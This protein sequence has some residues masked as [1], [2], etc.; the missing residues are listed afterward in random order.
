MSHP[1]LARR[2]CAVAVVAA[3]TVLA[4]SSASAAKVTSLQPWKASNTYLARVDLDGRAAPKLKPV[5]K[6]NHVRAGQWV[7]ITCQ[8]T[9]QMAY[10]SNIWDKVDGLY[11][12]DHYLKTY[13]DGFLA[14]VPRCTTDVPPPPP[15]PPPPA[16]PTRDELASAA[17]KVAFE[18]VYGSNWRIYKA[19]YPETPDTAHSLIWKTNGCSVPEAILNAQWHGVPIG[20]GFGYYAKLFVKSCD[21]H[22]FGY[23]NYG[24]K[25]NGL[26]LDPSATRRAQIDDRL[27]ANMDYQCKRIFSRKY[28]EAVQRGLCYKAS[29]AFY[30]AVHNFAGSHF[31]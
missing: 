25:T 3:A 10:G 30:W 2:A 14:G 22:D 4:P 19:K 16:G 31:S 1:V 23:R 17:D 9:G 28:V 20:K 29:D 24:S 5:A 21:R 12:P 6:V 18:R 27:H 7:H 13:T 11:V 8:T 26:K 15:P